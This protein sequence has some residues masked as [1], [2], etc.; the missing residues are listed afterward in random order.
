MK[1]PLP[2]A[3]VALAALLAFVTTFS[4]LGGFVD[5]VGNMHNMPLAIVNED[6]GAAI[7]DGQRNFGA[8]VL[9][10]VLA[11]NPALG[12]RVKWTVLQSR[13]EALSQ[14]SRD[15]YY[16]AIVVPPDFSASVVSL[17]NPKPDS[18]LAQ[19]EILANPAAGSIAG[20]ES[21]SIATSAVALV[22]KTTSAQ[23][24][25]LLNTNGA[26]IAPGAAPALADPVR[27]QIT[28]ARPIGPKSAR[29]LAPFY[30]AVMMTLAGFLGA[31]VVSVGVDF[32]TGTVHLDALAR[33]LRRP[34]MQLSRLQIWASKLVLTLVMSV[35]A[36]ALETWMAVGILGMDAPNAL[37]LGLFAVLGVASTA[38]V[39]LLFLTAFG[40]A[41]L[42]LGVLFTTIFGV[43]SAGGVYPLEMVPPFFRFLST[44]LPLRYMTDGTRS[45]LFFDGRGNAGLTTAIWVLAGYLLGAVVAGAA[46][47]FAIDDIIKRR[48]PMT[49]PPGRESESAP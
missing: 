43:P 38:I 40:T 15:K 30:F 47:A 32:T 6:A 48:P 9:Q 37:T 49:T 27:P 45:L 21:Q 5:P 33:R 34:P 35:L 44:W 23:L 1:H 26:T 19:I 46:T 4:Y 17:A 18:R 20:V 7:G 13:D 36:G 16:A 2:W 24:T 41:G 39:T 31:N 14:I 29:G 10:A 28:I 22:S 42:I 25:A 11:P 12:D 3:F 8:E